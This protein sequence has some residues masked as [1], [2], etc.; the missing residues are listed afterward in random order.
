MKKSIIKEAI[1]SQ[2]QSRV[3]NEG[4]LDAV[5]RGIAG[6][7][8]VPSAIKGGIAGVKNVAS[9][10]MGQFRLGSV[11]KK[12][13]QAAERIQDEWNGASNA[14]LDKGEKM[15][16]ASNPQVKK[17]GQVV[18]QNKEMLDNEV[19]TIANKIKQISQMGADQSGAQHAPNASELE[20]MIAPKQ[21]RDQ[22]GNEFTEYGVDRWLK[23][24]GIDA[25]GSGKT[26]KNHLSKLFMDLVSM[27]LNPLTMPLEK[28][29]PMIN[30]VKSME[31]FLQRGDI[32]PQE[33]DKKLKKVV[34]KYVKDGTAPPELSNQAGIGIKKNYPAAALEKAEKNLYKKL[35]NGEID[36]ESFQKQMAKLKEIMSGQADDGKAS[37][38]AAAAAPVGKSN[39]PAATQD[40]MV[41]SIMK[42]LET[43]AAADNRAMDAAQK[44]DL[45]EKVKKAVAD[46]SMQVKPG[47]VKG[48]GKLAMDAIRSQIGGSAPP[49]SPPPA[50]ATPTGAIPGQPIVTPPPA[51]PLPTSGKFKASVQNPGK[52]PAKPVPPIGSPAY[53]GPPGPNVPTPQRK[54]V[55]QEPIPLTKVK[56]Y[57]PTPKPE[58]PLPP[59]EAGPP[60][61]LSSFMEPQLAAPKKKPGASMDPD[62]MLPQSLQK[63]RPV[64]TGPLPVEDTGEEVQVG[65]EEKPG[66]GPGAKPPEDPDK[67]SKK[68]SKSKSK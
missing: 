63:K 42:Q 67:K 9:A 48:A 20:K 3:L 60:H 43:Q 19:D 61:S 68:K 53:S 2:L 15:E 7:K 45:L 40:M 57:S 6:I 35:K 47:D 17:M 18:L 24:F 58:L 1:Q 49:Q 34:K 10:G 22:F 31:A 59:E 5:K 8:N 33:F 14:I 37:G 56:P 41:Q 55:Q 46:A 36:P 29:Q 13:D 25:H 4:P 44:K 51:P 52:V 23:R 21:V 65:S 64:P 16:K 11:N 28:Q 27:N 50:A 32:S 12:L 38:G 66:F 39:I 26:L 54:P 30:Y 62:V